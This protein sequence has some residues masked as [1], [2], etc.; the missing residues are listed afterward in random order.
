[1]T[2]VI[3]GLLCKGSTRRSTTLQRGEKQPS[4]RA[5][6]M[7]GLFKD[8]RKKGLEPEDYDASR[9]DGRLLNFCHPCSEFT[10]AFLT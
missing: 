8:A 5:L 2:F 10:P 3:T 1:M 4:P 9:C 6:A 7:I